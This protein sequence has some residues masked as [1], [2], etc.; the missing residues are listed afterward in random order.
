MALY[1]NGFPATYQQM[2]PQYQQPYQQQMPQMPQMQAQ[3]QA[4]SGIIWVSGEAGARGYI[5]A[6]NTTVQLWDSDQ[7]VI[8]LK[9]ADASGMPSMKILDYTIRD[10]NTQNGPTNVLEQSKGNSNYVTKAEYDDIVREIGALKAQVERM[11][12]RRATRA[13]KREESEDEQ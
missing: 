12:A 6:P 1:N 8:Y 3:Q 4:Q 9:S 11:S 2:Y 5:V 7:K 13:A 10:Q